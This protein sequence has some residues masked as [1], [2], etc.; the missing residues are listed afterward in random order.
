MMKFGYIRINILDKTRVWE[1]CPKKMGEQYH[2]NEILF[3]RKNFSFL[4][5]IMI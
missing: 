1:V 3:W 5:I 2:M 4:P